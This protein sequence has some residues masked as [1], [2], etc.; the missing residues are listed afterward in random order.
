[1]R[2]LMLSWTA[3]GTEHDEVSGVLVGFPQ[4]TIFGFVESTMTSNLVLLLFALDELLERLQVQ[5]LQ[6]NVRRTS[7]V[8]CDML[9]HKMMEV[10]KPNRTV[11]KFPSKLL[12]S[13][14]RVLKAEGE[15][16]YRPGLRQGP[17]QC[18]KAG[19]RAEL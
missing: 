8:A 4:G 6:P 13:W 2:D 19:H 17:H 15:G 12:F 1:M 3:S 18:R 11:M 14:V 10:L 16:H 5:S 7:W 9:V